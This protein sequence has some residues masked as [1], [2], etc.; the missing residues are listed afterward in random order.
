MNLKR[1]QS[2]GLVQPCGRAGMGQADDRISPGVG[3]SSTE[4]DK[5]RKW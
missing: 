4:C 1:E 2:G 3:A 5:A